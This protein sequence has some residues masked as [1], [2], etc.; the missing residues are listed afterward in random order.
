MDLVNILNIPYILK[1]IELTWI[2]S[3][4]SEDH[5]ANKNQFADTEIIDS[6]SLNPDSVSKV[7]IIVY[8]LKY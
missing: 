7:F 6:L 3:L 4:Q 8:V 2:H 5:T 1:K